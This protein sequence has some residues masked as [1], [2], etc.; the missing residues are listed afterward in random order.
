MAS[1][2]D[3]QLSMNGE[4]ASTDQTQ[5]EISNIAVQDRVTGDSEFV[6]FKLVDTSR[7]GR[8]YI[9]GIADVVNP[10]TGKVE[11]AR[12]LAGVD[13]I[14][15][16]EQKDI[17]PSFVRMNRQSLEFVGKVC[18]IFT[19]EATKLEFARLNPNNIGS[20]SKKSG[21]RLEYFE[22]DP[23]KQ[24]QEAMKKQMAK[25]ELVIK[26]KDM[27]PEPMKKLA[28][29]LGIGFI[30][31]LGQLKSDDGVRSELMIRAD[32]D[33]VTVNKYIDSKE[34]EVSYM[35]RRAI[36]DAKIELGGS[37][38]NINWSNG[39]SICKMP[40]SRNALEYLTELAM[41]NSADGRQFLEQLK[42]TI[43]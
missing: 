16:K 39:G 26:V 28:A 15:Q 33:P 27:K 7:K 13:T 12:L 14:W 29:F 6:I 32:S 10:K 20:P 17:D 5:Q 9:D 30:D 38:G 11:R 36:L 18:R 41:T 31:E 4:P 34:V 19:W 3:V 40:Q 23:K 43:T 24:Q 22:Y 25:I 8:V 42:N 35:I 2:S 21:S 37:T 1:K